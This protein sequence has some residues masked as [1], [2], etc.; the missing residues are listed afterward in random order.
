MIKVVIFGYGWVRQFHNF[1]MRSKSKL[2]DNPEIDLSFTK[3]GDLRGQEFRLGVEIQR[4]H[5]IEKLRAVQGI[6]SLTQ[7][8]L[9]EYFTNY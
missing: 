9:C 4:V 5:S 6:W 2:P 7:N 1:I 8:E 3:K